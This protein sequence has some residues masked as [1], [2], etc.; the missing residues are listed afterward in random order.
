MISVD[1]LLCSWIIFNI[2]LQQ[3]KLP[4]D[5][6]SEFLVISLGLMT[7]ELLLLP[8]VTFVLLIPCITLL[9]FLCIGEAA[10]LPTSV[11]WRWDWKYLERL[12]SQKFWESL[13]SFLCHVLSFSLLISWERS[14]MCAFSQSGRSRQ[15][16]ASYRTSCREEYPWHYLLAS[17]RVK[18]ICFMAVNVLMLNMFDMGINQSILLYQ[19][20][21][22][23]LGLFIETSAFHE[24]FFELAHLMFAF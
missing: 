1:I 2:L 7:G 4:Q 8:S 9:C 12:V 16:T 6:C 24:L 10:G 17:S 3:I 18:I 15:T 19:L 21:K 14:Y 20:P 5:Y 22:Y 23:L 11:N 13:G